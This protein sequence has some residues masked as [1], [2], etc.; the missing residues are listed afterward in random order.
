MH[1]PLLAV[2]LAA[3]LLA[4]GIARAD[5]HDR[6]VAGTVVGG[7]A[8]GL[9]GNAVSRGGF[10]FPGTLIGAGL[11]AYAG[12]E[13][14]GAGC[15]YYRRAY[16]RRGYRHE[17]AYA[18]RAAYMRYASYEPANRCRTQQQAFYDARGALIYRPV[19]VCR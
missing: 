6:R 18:R 3:A 1:R 5:C 4:P 14:A 15:H 9:V 19:Q 17:H 10:R 13:I 16:Y 12:H 11:G 2:G 7:V 8:G